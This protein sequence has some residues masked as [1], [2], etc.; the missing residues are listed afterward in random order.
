MTERLGLFGGTFDP[1]HLGHL[2]L[3]EWARERLRL[4]RV[5]FVPAGD[6]PHKRART[7]T[8]AA[9]RLAMTELAIAGRE[10]FEISRVELDRT[11]PSYTVDTLRTLAS[12]RPHARWYLLIGEDSLAELSTWRD[13]ATVVRLATPVV[14]RRAGARSRRPA[15]VFGRRVVWLDDFAFDVSSSDVRARVRRGGAIRFLVPDV[16]ERFIAR[17]RLYRTPRVR[18]A[19]R[20]HGRRA[21]R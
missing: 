15:R 19:A 11:G 4:D 13:P 14:A 12:E 5:V 20:A 9:T 10:G 8:P 17:R 3:A 21:A 16:I 6:P 1:P 2:A 18:G 7:V